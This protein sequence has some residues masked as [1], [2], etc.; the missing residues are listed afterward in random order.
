VSDASQKRKWLKD[1]IASKQML[2]IP[3]GGDAL[4]TRLI[5]RAG[6]QAAYLSGFAVEGTHGFPDVGFLGMSEV[7]A[8]A[9]QMANAV[10]I[11]LFCDCDTGYG[12]ISNVMRTVR[13]F[14]RAGVAAI[15]LEDQD[16][17]KKCG[18]MAGKKLVSV[19]D[20]V[21]KIR[22]A[23]D[24]R[25]DPNLLII[26]RTDAVSIEGVDAAID[27]MNAYAEAGADLSMVLGP[28]TR[29]VAQRLAKAAPRPLVYL[30][31]ESLTMPMIPVAEL[32]KMGI[33]IAAFPLSLLLSA[34]RAM[35]RVLDQ[36][37]QHGTTLDVIDQT[38]VSWGRFN[39]LMGLPAIQESEKRYAV[40]P[41]AERRVAATAKA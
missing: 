18:S 26:G 17:P 40:A 4:S 2:V 41:A 27:R 28:Y 9:A 25:T 38:M 11:P 24:T 10:D 31:S 13:E 12:G 29:D 32:E 22:A 37:K 30:N 21:A 19:E 3:G 35:E 39:D 1:R 6:F 7:A 33:H 14:E 15:Q 5:E 8:R 34:T 36:I 16:L 20:M 23:A